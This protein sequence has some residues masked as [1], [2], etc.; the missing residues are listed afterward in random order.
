MSTDPNLPLV[1]EAKECKYTLIPR[2]TTHDEVLQMWYDVSTFIIRRLLKKKAVNITGLGMFTV[3][4]RKLD[5]GNNGKLCVQRPIFVLSEKFAQTHGIKYTKYQSLG[6]VPVAQLNFAA[7]ATNLGI[8][9]SDVEVCIK[10]MIGAFARTINTQRCG[11]LTF[12]DI[13]KL[14]VK[15]NKAKMKFSKDLLQLMDNSNLIS[16]TP[17][18][19]G[20]PRTSDSFISRNS[21]MSSPNFKSNNLVLPRIEKPETWER[22]PSV[23]SNH[24]ANLVLSPIEALCE[25]IREVIT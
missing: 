4:K 8:E 11:E 16:L 10:E 23:V 22:P 9:R 7:I 12:K 15:D 18:S 6:E 17:V 5:I 25:D 13:G 3:L 24:G 2:T 20:R 1:V 14:V 21:V 19:L